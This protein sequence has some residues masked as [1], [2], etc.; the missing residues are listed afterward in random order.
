M[1]N[2]SI[3]HYALIVPSAHQVDV[4]YVLDLAELPS[5]QMLQQWDL[6]KTSPRLALERRA[7]AQAADWVKNLVVEQNGTRVRPVLGR[8]DLSI[9]DGAGGLPVIRI[10]AHLTVAGKTGKFSYRDGNFPERA[11]W[12]EVVIEPRPGAMISDATPSEKDRSQALT[13]YPQDPTLAPPQDITAQFTSMNTEPL[14][15]KAAP[16]DKAIRVG[17]STPAVTEPHAEIPAAPS[18][19]VAARPATGATPAEAN[20]LGTVKRNDFLSRT[21]QGSKGPLSLGLTLL[22]LA[23]AFGVGALHAIEPG[24]GKTMVAAYLVGSRGTYQQAIFLGGMVTFTHTISVFALGLVTLFLSQYLLPETLIRVMGVISG[25]SIIWIGGL[26]LYRRGRKLLV[27]AGHAHSHAHGHG[28]SHD[29]GHTHSHDHGH[30]HDHSHTH[31]HGHSHALTHTHDGHTHS[32]VPEGEVTFG[33]L[34][35]LGISGGLVPCPAALVLLLSCISIGRPGLG[36]LLLVTFSIGLALVL[37]AIGMMVLAVKKSVPASKKPSHVAAWA[38]YAPV[39]SAALI[40]MIGIYMTGVA[41][42]AFPVV[43]FIG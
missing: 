21:L 14:V 15:T 35:A 7:H 17:T 31:D 2:F 19:V 41:V 43:R 28:H 34:V 30:S 38:R 27:P 42:G 37:M 16:A 13:A 18:V 33:S 36:L 6:T 23:A 12:K 32:H 1:G 25:V 9:Q 4:L 10:N 26:L 29:Q 20:S 39:F 8:T 11:G 24:H 22:C 5:F 3:N 40:F